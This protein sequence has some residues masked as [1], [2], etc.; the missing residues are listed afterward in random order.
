MRKF[1]VFLYIIVILTSFVFA[2]NILIKSNKGFK[3]INL[4]ISLGDF[5]LKN[6]YEEHAL[7][8]YNKA[9]EIDPNNKILLNN[10]GYYFKDKNPLLAEDYFKKALEIDPEYET[11]RNNLALLY[12]KLGQYDKSAEHLIFLVKQ[13]PDKINYN[14]DLAIN[15]ANKYYYQTKDYNDLTEAIKYFKIVYNMDSNFQ[16]TLENIKV[17]EEIRRM[18]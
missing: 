11:A 5:L 16:H 13:K 2:Q 6:N 17:L 3:D 4:Y 7:T 18:Y 14:Y 8:A 15:L 12:N 9:L 10:L 1:I